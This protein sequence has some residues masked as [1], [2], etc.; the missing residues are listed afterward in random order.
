MQIGS[1]RTSKNVLQYEF[2]K[3]SRPEILQFDEEV[4]LH[5]SK[6]HYIIKKFGNVSYYKIYENILHFKYRGG[7]NYQ[8]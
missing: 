3:L 4:T 1:S 5:L 2:A 8:T 7:E 6:I